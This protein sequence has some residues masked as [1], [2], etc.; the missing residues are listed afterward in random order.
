MWAKK[1]LPFLP[2]HK[3]SNAQDRKKPTYWGAIWQ[4]I[5]LL[6]NTSKKELRACWTEHAVHI[7]TQAE[8]KK[9]KIHAT[10]LF[11]LCNDFCVNENWRWRVV[12]IERHTWGQ[13]SGLNVL[14]RSVGWSIVGKTQPISVLLP[15][16]QKTSCNLWLKGCLCAR[17]KSNLKTKVFILF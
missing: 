11:K 7:C 5:V 3:A 1:F 8:W 12:S 4:N 17:T 15:P 10:F 16:Y 13:T 2:T 9:M 6:T 14:L